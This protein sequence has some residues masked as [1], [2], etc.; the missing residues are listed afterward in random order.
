MIDP[1]LYHAA[2]NSAKLP[3][4]AQFTIFKAYENIKWGPY[5]LHAYIIGQS[6]FISFVDFG[7]T[8]LCACTTFQADVPI[9][10]FSM[11][12]KDDKYTYTLP[13]FGN[14]NP[15]INIDVKGKI[16][17][18]TTPLKIDIAALCLEHVFDNGAMTQI[19][20]EKINDPKCAIYRTLHTYIEYNKCLT[21]W[22]RLTH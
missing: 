16:I 8:D 19:V 2:D 12:E 11:S 4:I 17:C 14:D 7:F 22:A 13:S 3:S 15:Q 5:T 9:Q 10:K 18:E 21:T 6:H 1:N 20:F